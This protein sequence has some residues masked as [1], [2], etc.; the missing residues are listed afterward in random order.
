MALSW[1]PS[2][3]PLL[4]ADFNLYLLTVIHC[5]CKYHGVFIWEFCDSFKR[6]LRVSRGSPGTCDGCQK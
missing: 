1:L 4:L 3:A 2:L 5:N 6:D